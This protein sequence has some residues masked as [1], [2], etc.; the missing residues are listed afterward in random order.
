[1]RFPQRTSHLL[2]IGRILHTCEWRWISFTDSHY[3]PVATVEK[4]LITCNHKWLDL[5]SN[6]NNSLAFG[7][8]Y[9]YVQGTY[10]LQNYS[11]IGDLQNFSYTPAQVLSNEIIQNQVCNPNLLCVDI[12]LTLESDWNVSGRAKLGRI[13]H[14]MFFRS[15]FK[16]YQTTMGFCLRWLRRL[17]HLVSSSLST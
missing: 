16:M 2:L 1:M 15:P 3:P 6:V 11:F 8:S 12:L 10:G 7:D 4:E 5:S 9:T 17:Y 13:S 14:I